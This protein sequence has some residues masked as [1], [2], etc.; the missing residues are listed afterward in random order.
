MLD[1]TMRLNFATLSLITPAGASENLLNAIKKLTRDFTTF[2]YVHHLRDKS[3]TGRDTTYEGRR[4][5]KNL[6]LATK[7][8]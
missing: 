3:E 8:F 6:C 4:F 5:R 1:L 2:S 7:L